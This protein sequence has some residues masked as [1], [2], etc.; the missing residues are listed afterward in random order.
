MYIYREAVHNHDILCLSM[1]N[2]E[3]KVPHPPTA[4]ASRGAPCLHEPRL[5]PRCPPTPRGLVACQQV[6]GVIELTSLTQPCILKM[7]GSSS[8]KGNAAGRHD[9]HASNVLKKQNAEISV[10]IGR[11][12]EE[13]ARGGDGG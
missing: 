7:M 12:E 5:G 13:L 8:R 3:N 10:R 9:S 1:Q 11:S 6:H 2:S 4:R